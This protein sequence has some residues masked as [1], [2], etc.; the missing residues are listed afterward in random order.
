MQRAF[1]TR[2][3]VWDPI[4]E[5]R[6]FATS[7]EIVAEGGGLSIVDPMT[8]THY[9]GDALVCRPFQPQIVL[10]IAVIL[11]GDGPYSR[12]AQDFVAAV[13]TELQPFLLTDDDR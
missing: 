7:C 1:F 2:G 12:L 8:A 4:V 5:S 9:S 11:P 13:R 10:E 6:L 3:L